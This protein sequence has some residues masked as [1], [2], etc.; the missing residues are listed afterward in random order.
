MNKVLSTIAFLFFA[1]MAMAQ[2]ARVQV[3]HNSPTP[4]T[5]AGPTVDIYV[6]GALL[7][8]LTA[9][10]Y[11]AATPFLDVPANADI[12]IDVKVSPSDVSDPSVFNVDLGQLADGGTYTVIAA[13]IVGDP[14]TPFNLYVNGVA[15]E[16]ADDP[17]TVEFS[18][19]HGSTDAPNVDV[20]AR[21]VGNLIEDLAFGSFEAYIP[22][23]PAQYFIDVRAAGDPNIVAT[24]DADLSGLTGGAATVFASGL[25]GDT[26]NFGLFAALPDGTVAELPATQIARLQL[27]HNSEDPTVDVYVNGDLYEGGFEYRDATDFRT[28]PAG[29]ALDIAVVPAGGDPATDNVYTGG[30]VTLEN[31]K[32][33]VAAAS[34]VVGNP[35]TPFTLFVNDM[36]QEAAADPANV[37]FSVLHGSPD[38]PGVDIDVRLV[39]NIISNITY[40]NYEG[41]FGVAPDVYY[42]DVRAMGDP[43]ILATYEAD[44]SGLTGGAATVF[45]S[46]SLLGGTFGLFA[47]LPDGTVVELPA[48]PVARLQVIHNSASPT[49]DIYANGDLLVPNFEYRTATPFI[50]VP[51]E[52]DINLAVVP[53]GGDPATDNVYTGGPL[54]LANNGTYVAVASGIVGDMTTPF[55]IFVNTMAREASANINE[56]DISVNHG[57]TDAPAV[58]VDA[59]AVA[60]LIENISYGEFQG[61]LGVT[62]GLYYLD[63][64]ATGDP[65]IVA[66][67]AAD[68]NGLAGNAITVFASGTLASSP[69]FGLFA[70]LA[71]GTVVELPAT[72]IARAQFIHNAADPTVDIYVNGGLFLPNFEYRTATEFN[73]V[74]AGVALDIAVVPAGGDPAT[75]N[76]YTGGPVTLDNGATYV[77]AAL[78]DVNGGT[79][80]FSL[81]VNAMARE[82]ATTND[83]IDLSVLHGSTDAPGV[84]VDARAIGNLIE[85]L[86]YGN[87]TMDYLSV[88]EDLY[89]LDIRATGDPNIVA[90]F[91]ADLN[92]LGGNAVTVFASGFL[93]SDPAFG[94][95]AALADGT[96]VELPATEIARV[97]FIHNATDPTVDIYVNGGLFLPNFEY[98]TATPFDFVPAGVALDIA[99]VPAGGDPATDNVYTGGPVTLVNGSTYVVTALGD[100]TG[101]TVPFSLAVN[102][103]ARE[104]ANN[105]DEI[106]ISVLH[107]SFDA[108]GVDVD[109]RLIGNLI[110]NLEYGNYAA[111]Y[112]SVGEDVYYLDIRATGDPNILATYE[113]DLNGLGGNAVTVFASGSLFGGTFGLFA[114]L[115]DGTVVELPFKL[116]A[117]LQ[118]VHNSPSPT[119][120]VYVNGGALLTDFEFRTASPFIFAD[121]GTSLD[122]AVVPAGGDPAT[123]N[124]YTGGPVTLENGETYVVFA[125]GI[126]GNGITPFT[127]NILTMGRENSTDGANFDFAIHHGSPSAPNVDVSTTGVVSTT[128][129]TDFAYG[130]FD[131][132]FEV[133]AAPYI[134]TVSALGGAV[135]VPFYA[136]L[137]D[138]AGEAAVLFASDLLTGTPEFGLFATFADGETIQIPAV[139]GAANVQVLHNSP[140]VNAEVVDIYINGDKTLDDVSFRTAT[141]FLELPA[142]IPLS[143][144]FAP[145]NSMSV[146]DTVA[147]FRLESGLAIDEN[148]I[149]AAGGIIGN[150]DTPFEL[151]IYAGALTTAANAGE[152]SFNALH[153]S[154]DA[155]NVDVDARAVGNL[156]ADLAYGDYTAGYLSVAPGTYFLD[157]RAAGDPNIVATYE[158]PLGLFTDQAITVFASGFLMD[159]PAFGLFAMD[160]NGEVYELEAVNISRGQIIHNSAG[161]PDVDIY[162]NDELAI[163]D[164]AFRNATGYTFLRAGEPVNVK[165]VPADGDPT[166]DAV[167][168]EDVTLGDNGETLVIMATGVVGNVD[169]PFG[170]AV[171][172]SGREAAADAGVDLL[173]YHGSTDAPEVDVVENSSSAILFDDIEY[174]EYSDDYVNVA[175]GSYILDVTPGNDNGT[176]VKSYEADVT[177]LEGG[178]AVVFA[179]GFFSGDDPA[180]GV[181]VALPDGTTF[182]L[183]E[184]TATND[185]NGKLSALSVYPNPVMDQAFVGFSLKESTEIRVEI[186]NATAQRVQVIDLGTVVAGEGYVEL[187]T[188][189]L[190]AGMYTMSFVSADGVAT[191]K[192]VVVK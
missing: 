66:T 57:S 123:D 163:E 58:D 47:A 39:G 128:L 167:Y 41:Y 116:V 26:P 125:D 131:G 93:G 151:Q 143:I 117:R 168:D 121:A 110:E 108:P 155:P 141:P 97:Q 172:G 1:V 83:N 135:S 161:A 12:T 70:A 175:A 140:D 34:G 112:I 174:G 14:T 164:L 20:D 100:V 137:E 5:A 192:F 114:A 182:P 54:N 113:A 51:A 95:F 60:T 188:A 102:A 36:A 19:F 170:L 40:G 77:I 79:V 74:P 176:V 33:Y 59:R 68:L 162:L 165:V 130:E 184:V 129:V 61:Y 27:I 65:N 2:T 142:E 10:P 146:Q 190:Q 160:V 120:D 101:G 178:A 17:T 139:A 147:N 156:I 115:A 81:A 119:V 29:V 38:A 149:V 86:E 76:V 3:I 181:W 6:N 157:V 191:K 24:F 9:V 18:V 158:A 98:R 85:N 186:Y 4:G 67:F 80:P 50:F 132:Y 90:T 15:K 11:R 48:G 109:A 52:A 148:Y 7:P 144:G 37:D 75:D 126:V 179:T 138:R 118:L 46:G 166:M 91:A 87:F 22:V 152:V 35:T 42:I 183:T 45:A 43:T 88:G 124:V 189:N 187:P 25:L 150:V 99:V 171:Y 134:I 71:D 13:G 84:D 185:L 55:T 169:T 72:E 30:P 53:A 104:A 69:A 44:L 73:F 111:D 177:T 64:R 89:Y 8:Q 105:N 16:A 78:G 122:I 32:T 107:G 145:S 49:V 127:L 94:L 28:V 21:F 154:P 173:L 96:V 133:P 63:V 103:T 62:P 92:G 23:P 82:A 106:D 180:F 56:V 153:G 159:D 136:D 31:G